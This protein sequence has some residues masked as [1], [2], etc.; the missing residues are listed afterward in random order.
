M[1]AIDTNVLLRYLLNDDAT[2]S[3]Q[4]TTL[5]TNSHKVLITDVVLVETV[6][7]LTGKKY[8]LD[9]MAVITVINAL[10]EEPTLC[11]EDEQAVWR[12][13]YAYRKAT[14]VFVNGRKKHAD[15]ADALLINK[16]HGYAKK[17]ATPLQTVYTFD[18]AAQQI[19]GA[20]AL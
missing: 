3:A 19:P 18:R 17:T 2:Q 16:S 7:A 15:F 13:L 20:T 6:Q 9:K 4:A 14:P 12:A 8:C 11:F 1:I 5:I 10:F